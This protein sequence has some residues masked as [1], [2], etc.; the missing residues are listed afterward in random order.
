MA[1]KHDFTFHDLSVKFH[2]YCFPF[3]TKL[4]Y[5]IREMEVRGSRYRFAVDVQVYQCGVAVMSS[6]ANMTAHVSSSLS[7]IESEQ[8]TRSLN[9]YLASLGVT[10]PSLDDTS[11]SLAVHRSNEMSPVSDTEVSLETP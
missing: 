2:R 4:H 9:Y 5:T 11:T 8:A 6:V 7:K 3:E 1:K 10:E